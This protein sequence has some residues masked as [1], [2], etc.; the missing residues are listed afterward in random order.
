M[1]IEPLEE[2]QVR[3]TKHKPEEPRPSLEETGRRR[4]FMMIDS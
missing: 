2:E 3:P 1:D 4:V